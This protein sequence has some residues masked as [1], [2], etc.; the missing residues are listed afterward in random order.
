MMAR[1]ARWERI[2]AIAGVGAA[3]ALAIGYLIVR[4]TTAPLGGSDAEY[5][6]VLLSERPK[7]EWVTLLRLIG[8]TLVLWFAALL[9]DRLRHMEG[10]PARLAEAAFGLGVV[11]AGVWLLSAFFNSA[12]IMLAADYADPAGARIAGVL[13]AEIPSVLTAGVVCTLLLATCMVTVRSTGFPKSYA[14]ATGAL[15]G[16]MLV[17]ALVD[18]YGPGTLG[19]LIVTLAL[20]WTAATSVLLLRPTVR[21][22]A[23]A[24]DA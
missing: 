5:A 6:R 13:A 10:E 16:L 14:Y 1:L 4:T 23:D 19:W 24:P 12:S 7:W 22:T 8:G 2:S 20:A 3:I 18:W 11:W 15:A 9:G 17:L 21:L